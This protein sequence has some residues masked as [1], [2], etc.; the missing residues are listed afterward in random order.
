MRKPLLVLT[1]L[2]TVLGVLGVG[3]VVG[4]AAC[5]N[6][7]VR[8]VQRQAAKVVPSLKTVSEELNREP[9]QCDTE[10][11]TPS[12]KGCTIQTITCGSVVEGSTA[13]MDRRWGDDFYNK[14]F[15]TP[16][17]HNYDEAPEAVYRLEMPPNIQADVYLD[18]DCAD[19]DVISM[20]WEETSRCPTLDHVGRLRECEMDTK[21]GGGKIRMTTVDDPQVYV[22]AVDGQQGQT[23]NF[24]LTV[25]CSTYR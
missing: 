2:V 12:P 15:C 13:T 4:I 16:Y 20:S 21:K 22:V 1:G 24:R 25:K 18:S 7:G 17:R 11:P 8:E 6:N 19:L 23:G 14:A 9:I 5:G 3:A 10:I